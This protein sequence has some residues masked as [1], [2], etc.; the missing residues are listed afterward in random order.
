MEREGLSAVPMAGNM[1]EVKHG[2]FV[3][4]TPEVSRTVH[5]HPSLGNLRCLNPRNVDA[6]LGT[7]EAACGI[8][9]DHSGTKAAVKVSSKRLLLIEEHAVL[10]RCG[11]D[12]MCVLP[13]QHFER[14]NVQE[15]LMHGLIWRR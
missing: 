9:Y 14:F 13:K 3:C 5:D 1:S 10:A 4:N 11:F 6:K 2:G 8:L 12:K 7:A 15:S